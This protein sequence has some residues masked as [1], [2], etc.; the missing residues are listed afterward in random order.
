MSI[1]K[2]EKH[3]NLFIYISDQLII[4]LR[5]HIIQQHINKLTM[6]GMVT[7]FTPA[8]INTIKTAQIMKRITQQYT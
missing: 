3:T 7:I 4:N 1:Y 6:M 5:N 8:N 2:M